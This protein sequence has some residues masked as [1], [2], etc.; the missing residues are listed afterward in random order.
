[1]TRVATGDARH[2]DIR[3]RQMTF[4]ITILAGTPGQVWLLGL[5]GSLHSRERHCEDL[6]APCL[7]ACA[8]AGSVPALPPLAKFHFHYHSGWNLL[9]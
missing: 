6:L 9:Y 1:M 5:G 4:S 2:K 3:N 8:C 7:A